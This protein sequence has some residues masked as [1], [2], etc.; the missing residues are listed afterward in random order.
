MPDCRDGC[1]DDPGKTADGVCGCGT[2]D[3]DRDADA[4]PDC[5]DVCP[6]DSGN[7]PDGD[8][9]C[10]AQDNC[11]AIANLSQI[12][13]DGDARGDACDLCPLDP[14]DDADLDG[15]CGDVD[16]CA[17]IANVDQANRDGD[18][19]GDACDSCPLDAADDADHDGMCGNLDNC[20]AVANPDQVD[21]DRDGAGDLCDATGPDLTGAWTSMMT[22]PGGRTAC[23]VLRVRNVGTARTVTSFAVTNRLIT[24]ATSKITATVTVIGLAPSAYKDLQFCHYNVLPAPLT[25][26]TFQ[27]TIDSSSKVKE[28]NEQN[29][30]AARVIP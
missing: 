30:Q 23:G 1:P 16:N 17:P 8:G 22:Y 9:A 3:T 21:S 28:A 18:G 19:R 29:N 25:G 4:T 6:D 26:S 13:R 15:V 12:D 20:P 5:H 27:A 14:L 2:P 7:D 10:A 11:P 24:G